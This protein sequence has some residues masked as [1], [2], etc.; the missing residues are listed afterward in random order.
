MKT[1]HYYND[2]FESKY[3]LRVSFWEAFMNFFGLSQGIYDE[4]IKQIANKSIK[5]ALTSDIKSIH[6]DSYKVLSD[7]HLQD[8]KK[9]KSMY[10]VEQE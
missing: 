9:V 7:K 6:Q 5:E 4:A 1:N 3:K 2:R 10:A 8:I